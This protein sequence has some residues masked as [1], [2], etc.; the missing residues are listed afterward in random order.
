M[1]LLR[2][3][4]ALLRRHVTGPFTSTQVSGLTLMRADAISACTIAAV[5]SP[6]VGI[7]AEAELQ[8]ANSVANS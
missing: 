7:I 6:M 8:C 5:Y 4:Q 2:G 3:K 1:N